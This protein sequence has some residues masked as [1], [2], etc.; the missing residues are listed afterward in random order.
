ML[1]YLDVQRMGSPTDGRPKA[2]GGKG[3]PRGRSAR[4]TRVV[5]AG[6]AVGAV[7]LIGDL[8]APEVYAA[9]V[10]IR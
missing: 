2:T 1:T 4:W 5:R 6:V 9:L 8:N 10:T 3:E 7:S